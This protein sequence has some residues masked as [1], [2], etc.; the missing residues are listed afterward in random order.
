M[1]KS[2]RRSVHF[3]GMY[4]QARYD[5][6]VVSIAEKLREDMLTT[7][8]ALDDHQRWRCGGQEGPSCRYVAKELGAEIH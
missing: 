4:A 6:M 5:I 2:D 1:L 7:P 3:D 8:A